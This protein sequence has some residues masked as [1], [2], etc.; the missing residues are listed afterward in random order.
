MSVISDNE[1]IHFPTPLHYLKVDPSNST[2]LNIYIYIREEMF[3][4]DLKTNQINMFSFERFPLKESL[5]T[6]IICKL[7]FKKKSM[8]YSVLKYK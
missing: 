6:D 4:I 3:I 5:A 2:C 8:L 7:I 1:I